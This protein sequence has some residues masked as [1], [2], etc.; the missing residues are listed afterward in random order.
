MVLFWTW[1]TAKLQRPARREA[2]GS[3]ETIQEKMK[4]N[5]YS[6]RVL[7]YQTGLY[8]VLLIVGL[9]YHTAWLLI[10]TTIVASTKIG[11]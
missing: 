7:I 10:T 9:Q 2:A 6:I 5:A 8:S 4:T 11:K 3:L 1:C